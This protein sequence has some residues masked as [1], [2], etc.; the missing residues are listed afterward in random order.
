M[1]LLKSPK[2]DQYVYQA[3]SMSYKRCTD[4]EKESFVRLAVFDGS[5][6]EKAARAVMKKNVLIQD[7]LEKLVRHSLIKQRSKHRYSIHLLIKHFLREQVNGQ[8]ETGR[9]AGEEMM[10][11]QRLMVEYYLNLGHELT[12]KSYCKDGYKENREVLKQE[13]H[14][15]QNVLKICCKRENPKI[16][17]RLTKSKI[18]TTSARFFLIFVRTIIPGSLFD[19]FLERCAK[20]ANERKEHGIKINFDC[21][22]VEQIR[23]K[24]IGKSDEFY[25]IKMEEIE[26]EFITY[27]EKKNSLCSFY[28]YQYGQYLERKGKRFQGKERLDLY[29]EAHKQLDNSLKLRKKL[30]DTFFKV[31]DT[32]FSLLQLGNICKMISGAKYFLGEASDETGKWTEQAQEHYT[33][34]TELSQDHLGKH[35]LTSACYKSHGDFFFKIKNLKKAEDYYTIAKKIREDLTLDA[36]ERHALLLNNLGQCLTQTNRAKEAIEVLKNARDMAEKLSESDGPNMCKA[37]VYTSLAIAYDSI[38]TCSE[39][40]VTYAKKAQEFEGLHD[41]I[42]KATFNKLKEISTKKTDE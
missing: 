27:L 6:S 18:Y 15:I 16:T 11:A 34:A 8:D 17:E 31:A 14:N 33:E 35:D 7:I 41:I 36:S 21:L 2:S 40:A 29:I 42:P 19:E 22:I 32:I 20:L 23:S 25:I 9:R 30:P 13:A 38:Q 24:T 39:E 12:M 3:I 37:K 4:E 1:K 26:R 10:Q 28:Y 5:F